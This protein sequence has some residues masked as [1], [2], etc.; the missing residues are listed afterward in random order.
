MGPQKSLKLN[1]TLTEK[2]VG[3]DYQAL[4]KEE[5]AASGQVKAAVQD[6][7]FM[8]YQ[9]S[10]ENSSSLHWKEIKKQQ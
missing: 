9:C 6:K 3:R 5:S 8:C 10:R 2:E 4:D 7:Q 1:T